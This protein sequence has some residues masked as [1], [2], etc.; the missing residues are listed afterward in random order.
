MYKVGL[1]GG[2]A[3]GK[4]TVSQVLRDLGAS[5]VDFDLVAKEL[6]QPYTGVW[7]E[8]VDTFGRDILLK[9]ETLDR[10]ALGQRVFNNPEAMAKLNKIMHPAVKERVREIING[11]ALAG[12]KIV[13]LDVA[14]LI[15]AR[16]TSLADEV[17][18]VSVPEEVQIERLMARNGFSR[19]EAL[20]RVSSQMSLQEKLPYADKVIDNSGKLEETRD[21]VVSLWQ[22]LQHRIALRDVP[23]G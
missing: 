14:L 12:E 11:L 10:K 9:D 16:M 2:I 17:W 4:S 20:A 23:E 8:I 21:K 19:N 22:E 6:Q 18:L 15:E 5:I 3:S 13:V 1:T 7:Q